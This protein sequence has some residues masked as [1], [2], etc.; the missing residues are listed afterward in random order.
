M[1][2]SGWDPFLV[3]ASLMWPIF[4]NLLFPVFHDFLRV[5]SWT[6]FSSQ[7]IPFSPP[8]FSPATLCSLSSFAHDIHSYQHCLIGDTV[9]ALRTISLAIGA[10]VVQSVSP[11]L[12]T[13]SAYSAWHP[14]AV[15][16]LR[17]GLIA[18]VFPRYSFSL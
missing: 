5:S 11:E 2:Y 8:L 3:S 1:L 6:P 13:L 7:S 16:K 17:C 18:T 10:Y 9:A 4:S 12:P 15:G 14:P